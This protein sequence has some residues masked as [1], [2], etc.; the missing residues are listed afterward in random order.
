M[1]AA[2]CFI[3]FLTST[4]HLAFFFDSVVHVRYYFFQ[5]EQMENALKGDWSL[6][7]RKEWPGRQ[8][9]GSEEDEFVRMVKISSEEEKDGARQAL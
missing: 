5:G 7:I 4:R 6:V 1:Q 8:Q 9:R 2:V 3:G